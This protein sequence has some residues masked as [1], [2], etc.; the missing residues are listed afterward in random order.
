MPVS[1]IAVRNN[2]STGGWSVAFPT[3]I[4]FPVALF[5]RFKVEERGGWA[6]GRVGREG[7]R[8][9]ERE[10]ETRFR[11]ELARSLRAK[12]RC[13]VSHFATL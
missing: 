9:R 5:P 13:S 2:F 7:E 6:D 8:E 4:T 1:D 3:A 10:R 11:D 12:E